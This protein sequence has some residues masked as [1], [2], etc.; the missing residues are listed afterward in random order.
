[1][2]T[3]QSNRDESYVASR[4]V[5]RESGSQYTLQLRFRGVISDTSAVVMGR[6]PGNDHRKRIFRIAPRFEVI[7]RLVRLPLLLPL[8]E[9]DTLFFFV[10][11]KAFTRVKIDGAVVRQ[12]EL[13]EAQ[14]VFRINRFVAKTALQVPFSDIGGIVT[15]FPKRL[16]QGGSLTRNDPQIVSVGA[17]I[18]W[19]LA[20]HQHTAVRRANGTI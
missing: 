10:P 11:V 18:Q 1:M 7:N 9:I 13:I 5:E 8:I 20:R 15:R 19:V 14:S 2:N 16:S 3:T 17:V 12:K 4:W 6:M